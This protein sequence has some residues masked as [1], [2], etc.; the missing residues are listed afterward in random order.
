MLLLMF[1][2]LP[3]TMAQQVLHE[4]GTVHDFNAPKVQDCSLNSAT[5]L[6]HY[7]LQSSYIPDLNNQWVGEK[8]IYS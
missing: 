2:L 4:C 1:A 8:T 5:W 6:N 7:R 3:F